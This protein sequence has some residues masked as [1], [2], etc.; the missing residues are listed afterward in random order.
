MRDHQ[1]RRSPFHA[2]T[3]A[4]LRGADVRILVPLGG[5]VPLVAAAARS[6]Y[7]ELLEA[8]ARIFEYGP[9][10]LHAKTIVVDDTLAQVGTANFD[11]RSFRLNFEV[12]VNLYDPGLCDELAATFEKDLR[13][14]RE[15]TL[16]ML[17]NAS[18]PQRFA[19]SA[20][21]LLSPIL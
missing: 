6:Y 14:A 17:R 4:A 1:D 2:L 18:F 7:P 8:G 10:V 13:H 16:D 9:P 19:A 20:A 3:T 12:A 15:V 11:N 5:D 21:R